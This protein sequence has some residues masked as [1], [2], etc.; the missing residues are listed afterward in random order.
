MVMTT[1]K[2]PKP[3]PPQTSVL[4]ARLKALRAKIGI[5]QRDFAKRIYISQSLYAELEIGNRNINNRIIHLIATQFNVNK[6]YIKNGT[7]P[8]FTTEPPDMNLEHLIEIFDELD[9]LLQDYLLLQAKE[10]LKIQ[11]TLTAKK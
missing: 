1:K 6:N 11:H 8:M 9:E 7:E 5:S 10:I 4:P 3:L 2:T